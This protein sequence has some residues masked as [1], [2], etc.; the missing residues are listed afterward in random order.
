MRSFGIVPYVVIFLL[1]WILALQTPNP[2]LVGL[3]WGLAALL[4]AD[5]LWVRINAA[6]L[7]VIRN[8]PDR[9][10]TGRTIVLDTTI[11]NVGLLPLLWAEISDVIPEELRLDEHMPEG[12]SLGPHAEVRFT[13][14]ATCTLRGYYRIGP[15]SLRVADPFGLIQR[16]VIAAEKRSLI[17]YPRVVPLQ[18]LHLPSPSALAVLPSRTPLLEDPARLIGVREYGPT[19]SLRRIHWT[20]TA[21]MGTLMVKQFEYG[22]SRST[23][24]CLDLC[25]YDYEPRDRLHAME[26]AIV[27]AASLASHAVSREHLEVGLRVE[28]IDPLG[29]ESSTLRISPGAAPANLMSILELLARVQ[30][31]RKVDFA[32][33]LRDEARR[34]PWGSTLVAIVGSESTG[35]SETLLSLK[36]AGHAVSVIVVS[37]QTVPKLPHT[38]PLRRVWGDADLVRGQYD[39]RTG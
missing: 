30:S 11:R 26:L 15:M 32:A 19:D 4:G 36:R 29:D 6:S 10:Y 12:V 21:R 9:A 24:L 18:R 38:V 22:V 13:T 14:S 39:R 37:R 8:F 27:V 16:E 7:R 17:V 3:V 2:A 5:Y 33:V 23:M 35:L 28:G 25:R 20:A 34:L 31:S 1:V